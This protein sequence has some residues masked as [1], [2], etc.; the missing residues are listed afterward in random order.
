MHGNQ[1]QRRATAVASPPIDDSLAAPGVEKTVLASAA[2]SAAVALR[3]SEV[4]E[5]AFSVPLHKELA[6]A[7]CVAIR[8]TSGKTISVQLIEAVLGKNFPYS[9]DDAVDDETAEAMIRQL[10]RITWA[11]TRLFELR[12]AAKRLK[13]PSD[14][15]A[16]AGVYD[17]LVDTPRPPGVGLAVDLRDFSAEAIARKDNPRELVHTGFRCLDEHSVWRDAQGRRHIGGVSTGQ[18]ILIGGQSAGGKSRLSMEMALRLSFN[19]SLKRGESAPVWFASGEMGARELLDAAGANPEK[20]GHRWTRAF[21]ALGQPNPLFVF[22]KDELMS[23]DVDGVLDLWT[24]QIERIAWK[25]MIQGATTDAEILKGLPRIFV[26][27]YPALYLPAGM[28][29]T[30]GIDY[31]TLQLKQFALRGRFNVHKI[32]A[33][34]TYGLIVIAP[35]QIKPEKASGQRGEVS[36]PNENWFERSREQLNHADVAILIGKD[37]DAPLSDRRLLCAIKWRHGQPAPLGLPIYFKD[38]QW[39]EAEDQVGKPYAGPGDEFIT[40]S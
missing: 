38:G 32:P 15:D 33:L 4:G 11:S 29:K 22:A 24:E 5:A 8:D 23:L 30:E 34:K 17:A 21:H 37:P 16:L 2:F 25:N 36:L 14:S 27:D 13:D 12:A 18:M 20:G 10:E 26:L 1:A 31:A 3:L 7:V 19:Y 39:V 28:G 9:A 35:A 6:R 40:T